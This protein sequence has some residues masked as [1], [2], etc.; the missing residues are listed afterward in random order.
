MENLLLLAIFLLRFP[1]LY[2]T[3]IKIMFLTT[4]FVSVLI[5]IILFALLVYR[6][7]Q[8]GSE[9]VPLN[10][11]NGLIFI[12]F[13]FLSLSVVN[14]IDTGSF[15]KIYLK[16]VIGLLVYLLL[17]RFKNDEKFSVK[18]IKVFLFGGVISLCGQLILLIFPDLWVKIAGMLVHKNLWQI[19]NANLNRGRLFDDTF[20]E[21]M[22]PIV[23]YLFL[24]TKKHNALKLFMFLLLSLTGLVVFFSN[25]RYR[26]LVFVASI[27]TT[28]FCFINLND[29]KM[30]RK[31]VRIIKI[32]FLLFLFFFSLN[33]FAVKFSNHTI[34]DR[35]IEKI[36]YD[37]FS[38][39]AWRLKMFRRS[40]EI[41]NQKLMGVGLGNMFNY[42]SKKS[43]SR[44]GNPTLVAI[45]ALKSGPHNVFFQYLAAGGW[46]L[47]LVFILLLAFYLVGDIQSLLRSRDSNKKIFI[48]VFW[49]LIFV[50][51]MFPAINLTFY[52]LFFGLRALI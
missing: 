24:K 39:V 3:P 21:I 9:L 36:E 15:L 46:G 43:L 4:H 1:P 48:L 28:S 49:S 52:L 2:F 22:T 37:R 47:F 25:F 16:I 33:F 12:F 19:T 10:K 17:L 23:I 50:V 42:V 6:G 29:K 51:Q 26:F 11:E 27:F 45:A 38:S 44:W 41:A 18:V 8:G 5:F 7:F 32:V 30:V 31:I 20:L 13:L 35:F 34:V 40:V 14:V